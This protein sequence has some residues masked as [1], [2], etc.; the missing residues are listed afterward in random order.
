M[1]NKQKYTVKILRQYG[2]LVNFTGEPKKQNLPSKIE[3]ENLKQWTSRVLG[4]D[5]SDVKIYMPIRPRGSRSMER[6]SD[7][8]NIDFLKDILRSSLKMK[9]KEVREELESAEHE[10]KDRVKAQKA[11]LYKKKEEEIKKVHEDLA[12]INTETLSD[13]LHEIHNLEPSV[14]EFLARF[15][16]E[17][18]ANISTQELLTELITRH[19]DVVIAARQTTKV[20]EQ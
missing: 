16:K 3:G 11:R 5:V 8:F 14:Q 20:D 15:I 10:Y 13:I 2:I 7:E 19:N 9:D 4:D 17:G 1:N 12:S 18:E 6:M